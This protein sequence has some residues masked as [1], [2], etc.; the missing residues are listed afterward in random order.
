MP[1]K[2]VIHAEIETF[3]DWREAT[4]L[5]IEKSAS[6]PFALHQLAEYCVGVAHGLAQQT[7][8]TEEKKEATSA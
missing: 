4:A 6:S 8:T 5:F 7:E 1:A 2:L 3:D